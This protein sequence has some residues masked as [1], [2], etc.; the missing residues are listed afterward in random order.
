MNNRLRLLRKV[1][2]KTQADIAAV[3]GIT[4]NA[5][6]Y[7]ERGYVKIHHE[8]LLRLA[9]YYDVSVDFIIGKPFRMTIPP[10]RWD[11]SLRA[12]YDSANEDMRTYMEYKYGNGE[13]LEDSTKGFM[14]APDV[15]SNTIIY[16]RDGKLQ[17]KE[18]SASQMKMLMAIL[19]I[20]IDDGAKHGQN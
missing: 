4:Q 15:S 17:Q 12:Q 9:D 19:D 11:E 6:S 2:G 14:S 7:W 20:D 1:M 3:I 8:S 16:H 10:D 13:G 5:Y 18:L